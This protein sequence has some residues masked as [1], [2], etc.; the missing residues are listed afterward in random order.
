M[1]D[2]QLTPLARRL[3]RTIEP[4]AANVYFAPECHAAYETL[5]FRGSRGELGGAAL[6]DGSAYMTS[7]GAALGTVPGPVVAA[8]FGVFKPA[9]VTKGVDRGW[10]LTDRDTI[11][12]ARLAGACASLDRLLD[13]VW[14]EA[15]RARATEI[16]QAMAA[17][18]TEPARPLFAGLRSLGWPGTATGDLWR[19]ADLVREFRGDAHVAAWTAAGFDAVEIGV[20]SDLRH[21]LPLKSWV[22]SRGWSEEEL[23]DAVRRLTSRGLLG[24]DGAMTEAGSDAREA[25]EIITDR[26]VAPMI[27][28]VGLV[29]VGELCEIVSPWAKAIAAGGGVPA[30][31]A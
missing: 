4:L 9:A 28:A 15:G 26:Q 10:S 13:G 1:D 14:D 17:A 27:E 5:G 25:V 30:A 24:G 21:G 23:D 2:A 12:A 6:P 8:A 7:R 3:Q 29:A 19:G 18:G 16:L 11:L 22:R 31:F 20:I